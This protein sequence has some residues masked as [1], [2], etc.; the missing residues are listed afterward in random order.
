MKKIILYIATSIDGRIAEPGGGTEFLSGYPIT[1]TMDYGYR[2]F[3][4]SIDTIVM[5]GRSWRETAS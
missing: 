2:E 1:E 3:F 5:G 4:D